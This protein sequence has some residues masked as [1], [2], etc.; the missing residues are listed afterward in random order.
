MVMDAAFYTK[1]N[2][3]N[4]GEFKW[5]TRVPETLNEVKKLYREI[6]PGE[7]LPLAEGYTHLPV[8]CSYGDSEQRWLIVH[9]EQACLRELKTFEKNLEKERDRNEKTLKHLRNEAYACEADAEKAARQFIKK[10]RYQTFDYSIIF[11]KR[12]SKGASGKRRIA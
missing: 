11:R 7:M 3:Q 8:R 6:D 1:E 4:S 2:I 12:Y 10:L 9:S 5:V